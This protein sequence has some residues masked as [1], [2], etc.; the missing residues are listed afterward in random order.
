MYTGTGVLSQFVNLH[1]STPRAAILGPRELHVQE[2]NTITLICVI[3]Q[4][5]PPFVFWYHDQ[6][7]VNYDTRLSVETHVEGARTHSR[8][9]ISH[10]S[11]DD[12]NTPTTIPSQPQNVLTTKD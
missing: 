2:G 11:K 10:A 9:T 5:K 1:V 6:Q 3:Q 12:C 7:M 4:G 8:L